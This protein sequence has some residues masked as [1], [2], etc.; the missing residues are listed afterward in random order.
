MD[1]VRSIRDQLSGGETLDRISTLAGADA[2]SARIAVTAAVPTIL[3]SL[4]GLASTEDGLRK[5]AR[6]LDSLDT[7]SAGDPDELLSGGDSRGLLQKGNEQLSALLGDIRV[8]SIAG[9]VGRFAGMDASA[10]K[11]LL[12]LLLPSVLSTVG[13]QWKHLGGSIRGLSELLLDQQKDVAAALPVGFSLA[14]I[15]GRSGMEARSRSKGQNARAANAIAAYVARRSANEAHRTANSA[16]KWIGFLWCLLLVTVA[17]WHFLDRNN[18]RGIVQEWEP[19]GPNSA[20]TEAT[21]MTAMRLTLPDPPGVPDVS[22]MNN[23]WT[24]VFTTAAQMLERI[25]DPASAR[26]AQPHLMELGTAIDGVRRQFDQLPAAGQ[27]VLGELIGKNLAPVK[28]QTARILAMRGIDD[29]TKAMLDAITDKLEGVNLS[30]VSQ[31]AT[32]VLCKLTKTLS[33]VRDLASSKAALPALQE[34]SGKID[35]LKRVQT[36]LSPEGQS[37]LSR[38]ILAARGS[39]ESMIT[40]VVTSLGPDA[41]AIK[42]ILDNIAWNL[43]QLIQRL[44]RSGGKGNAAIGSDGNFVRH[45]SRPSRSGRSRVPAHGP[46]EAPRQRAGAVTSPQRLSRLA[47]RRLPSAPLAHGGNLSFSA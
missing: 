6:L 47:A 14:E 9:S 38:V 18:G 28:E 43:D 39:L 40:K 33:G 41:A 27:E 37:M 12:A 16:L 25:R 3:S 17:L 34:V 26:A 44:D 23:D 20:G 5:V 21:T 8:S 29:P 7:S 35:E 30:Q 42:P 4:A 46:G 13:R 11:R 32:N 24:S 36:K 19:L 2:Q 45:E 31:D 22:A 10:V 1:L 15:P